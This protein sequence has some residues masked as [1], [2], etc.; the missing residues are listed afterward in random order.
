MDADDKKF[1]ESGQSDVKIEIALRKYLAGD[2]SIYKAY[3]EQRAYSALLF[4]V[5]EKKSN[6]WRHFCKK[7]QLIRE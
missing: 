1:A 5:K 6:C 2:E 4:L 3:I 7:I